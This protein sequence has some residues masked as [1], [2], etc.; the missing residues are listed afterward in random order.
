MRT[1]C[2]DDI[3]RFTG[4]VCGSGCERTQERS[5]VRHEQTRWRTETNA[6]T[7]WLGFLQ[8]WCNQ[9]DARHGPLQRLNSVA[10]PPKRLRKCPAIDSAHEKWLRCFARATQTSLTLSTGRK[11][12]GEVEENISLDRG[13]LWRQLQFKNKCIRVC[14]L[15]LIDKSLQD[16]LLYCS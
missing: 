7:L 4:G 13:H 14:F 6:R 16:K 5:M 10:F 2:T 12:R 8:R 11:A 9:P 15:W 3:F 1:L